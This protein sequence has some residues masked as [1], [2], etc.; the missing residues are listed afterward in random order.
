MLKLT[1]S[2]EKELRGYHAGSGQ[3]FISDGTGQGLRSAFI[4]LRTADGKFYL[5]LGHNYIE[6]TP[7]QAEI[8]GIFFVE[9][10]IDHA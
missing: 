4:G 7:E 1:K 3:Y 10:V 2:S 8:V 6:L 5:T 9:E